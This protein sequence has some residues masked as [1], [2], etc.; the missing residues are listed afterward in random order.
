MAYGGS[1][2]RGLIGFVA[3]SLRH[4]DSNVR[5][6]PYLRSTPQSTA[7]P[8]SSPQPHGSQSDFCFTTMGIPDWIFSGLPI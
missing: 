5:S 1:Q 8:G 2:A 4:S 3:T 7:T 6:V